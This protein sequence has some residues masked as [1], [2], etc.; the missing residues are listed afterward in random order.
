MWPWE[1]NN[2]DHAADHGVW[3]CDRLAQAD[4]D[5]IGVT[6]RISASDFVRHVLLGIE[7]SW[8]MYAIPDDRRDNVLALLTLLHMP[9]RCIVKPKG[10]DEDDVVEEV[11]LV[12]VCC[13]HSQ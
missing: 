1:Y 13:N 8:Q 3:V 12:C 11:S 2:F 7:V 5:P 6:E 4:F 10:G 9:V